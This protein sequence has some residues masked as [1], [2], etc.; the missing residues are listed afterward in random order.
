MSNRK[1]NKGKKKGK[2]GGGNAQD[3]SI[4]SLAKYNDN[5]VIFFKDIVPPRILT[6]LKFVC[7]RKLNNAGFGTASIQFNANGIY[8]F[9]PAVASNQVSGF[10]ELGTI[11][12]RYRVFAVKAKCTFANMDVVTPSI[13]NL[14]FDSEPYAA[15]AKLLS[16]YD[17]PNQMC[18]LTTT[19]GQTTARLAMR[20]R[21]I[22]VTGDAQVN[23]SNNWSG[24]TT[25]NPVALWYVSIAADCTPT[26]QTYTLGVAIRFEAE[27]EVEWYERYDVDSSL[28]MEMRQK[29]LDNVRLRMLMKNKI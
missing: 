6:R 7:N 13:I 20:R 5:K 21:A 11:W 3:G 10:D 25:S 14:G 19:S 15:N 16:N 22:D 24:T 23:V 17:G 26:G 2:K 9:D 29:H 4:K 8:D 12:G 27:I 28:H 1:N 18:Q